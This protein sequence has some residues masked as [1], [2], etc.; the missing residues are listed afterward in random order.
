MKKLGCLL[1]IHDYGAYRS[2]DIDSA[3]QTD[4]NYNIYFAERTC[5]KCHKTRSF[6]RKV[7]KENVMLSTQWR[8]V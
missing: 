7:N 2:L 8:K 4:P 6:S 1:G 5:I 3:L